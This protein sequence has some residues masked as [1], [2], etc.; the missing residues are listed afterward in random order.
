MILSPVPRLSGMMASVSSLN[1]EKKTM[2][3]LHPQSSCHRSS[4]A[5]SAVAL[6]TLLLGLPAG[7]CGG[8]DGEASGESPGDGGVRGDG[9]P[10]GNGAQSSG[11][12]TGEPPIIEGD[13][14]IFP[15][16]NPWNLDISE[17]PVHENSDNFIESV[18]TDSTMHPDFGTVWDG[19]PIG[20]PYVIVDAS[21]A[22]I[23]MNYTAYGDESTPGPFPL[24]LDA[25][26]EGGA[27]SDGD[28]H[29]IAVDT[30]A[31]MLYELYRAF[32]RSAQWDADSGVA[33]DL[34]SNA[35]HPEGCT[36]ADAAGLPIFPGLVRYDEVVE[37]GEIRHAL[38]FT[39]AQSQRAYIHP[40]THYASSNTDPNT[41]PMGLRFRMKASYDCSSY[42]AEVQVICA[43]LKTY[44]M[45]MA[46]N[47]SNWYLSGAPD[48]RWN[49]DNLRDIKS[50]PGNAFEVVDTGDPIVTDAPDC[51]L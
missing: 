6:M 24:P 51:S 39:V 38:R 49:D 36:S 29:A 47:G 18:G 48:E 12:S 33:W 11:G 4:K 44:G 16:D 22:D 2:K 34:S 3:N 27:S 50:I 19:A 7:A 41:P 17:L 23:G 43:A 31:C 26:I 42:S 40:A 21:Q 9:D 13:C 28:R 30:E 14:T 20:I 35:K 32:P 37:R 46:D 10:A 25:P 1:L 8:S 15:A 45:I 5:L